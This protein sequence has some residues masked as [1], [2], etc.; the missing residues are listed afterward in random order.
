MDTQLTK[1]V[2]RQIYAKK[3]LTDSRSAFS[4]AL[5]VHENKFQLWAM[6]KLNVNH[7][8]VMEQRKNLNSGFMNSTFWFFGWHWWEVYR[9][10]PDIPVIMIYLCRCR[11]KAFENSTFPSSI[12]WNLFPATYSINH[13]MEVQFFNDKISFL[14]R[15]EKLETS[16]LIN[17]KYLGLR[18][19]W[20]VKFKLFPLQFHEFP[21]ATV[22][23]L[24]FLWILILIVW[25]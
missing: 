10:H 13:E 17:C 15:Y 7:P 23:D 5:K 1:R 11:E 8:I 3:Y 20:N 22:V 21:S 24:W 2:S 19:M 18:K 14:Q 9:R 16:N 25:N 6:L 4:Y 12:C